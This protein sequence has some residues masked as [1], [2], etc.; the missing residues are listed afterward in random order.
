MLA[1][2]AHTLCC[3]STPA[4]HTDTSNHED[5]ISIQSYKIRN[6]VTC[7]GRGADALAPPTRDGAP[8]CEMDVRQHRAR[9]PHLHE[10]SAHAAGPHKQTNTRAEIPSAT[11]SPVCQASKI[12]ILLNPSLGRLRRARPH[13][14]PRRKAYAH[15]RRCVRVARTN[16]TSACISQASGPRT[17]IRDQSGGRSL[18]D[19][20][21]ISTA[22]VQ[23]GGALPT[24][25]G[26]GLHGAAPNPT[27]TTWRRRDHS[28]LPLP[29]ASFPRQSHKLLMLAE[30]RPPLRSQRAARAMPRHVPRRILRR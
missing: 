5:T 15:S 29:H 30:S 11:P 10:H 2:N 26:G 1:H 27:N 18:T 21:E 7:V 4:P 25:G 14:K 12:Q 16:D 24:V 22:I 23:R 20:E 6:R 8:K 9:T 3:H 19:V 13:D 28:S 17:A